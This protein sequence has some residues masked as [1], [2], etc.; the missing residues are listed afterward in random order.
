MR[1]ILVGYSLA[2]FALPAFAGEYVYAT[3]TGTYV[4]KTVIQGIGS[5]QDEAVQDATAAKPGGWAL[6]P[7]EDWTYDQQT[8]TTWIATRPIVHECDPQ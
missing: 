2:L 3:K 7:S 1:F 6:S 4:T 5:S 8:D